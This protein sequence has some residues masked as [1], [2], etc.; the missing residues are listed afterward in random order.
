MI[1]YLRFLHGGYNFSTTMRR[2]S[3]QPSD[4]DRFENI[5]ERRRS[6]NGHSKN[7]YRDGKLRAEI[8]GNFSRGSASREN[9]FDRRAREN[10]DETRVRTNRSIERRLFR[11]SRWF[12][13]GKEIVTSDRWEEKSRA[14]NKQ[15]GGDRVSG[16]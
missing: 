1:P 14:T 6:A 16:S 9:S 5:Y 4:L 2:N 7:T 8:F 12:V 11:F 10:A 15:T 13:A 3:V